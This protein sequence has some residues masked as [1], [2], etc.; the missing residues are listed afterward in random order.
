MLLFLKLWWK[1]LA[2]VAA[3]LTLLMLYRA[4]IAKAEARGWE[5]ATIE[6]TLAAAEAS[7]AYQAQ[8]EVAARDLA[9]ARA[10]RTKAVQ[11]AK[12]ESRAYYQANP[13]AAGAVCLSPD[14]VRVQN[15]ARGRVHTSATSGGR[16]AL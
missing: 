7:R 10:V 1:P 5:R 4:Q 2:G 12:D 3:V 9:Q 15:E 6:A 14:R 16:N 11:K 8:L 13:D